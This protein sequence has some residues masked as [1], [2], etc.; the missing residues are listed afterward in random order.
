MAGTVPD[1]SGA[2]RGVPSD[3]PIE[4]RDS[5]PS[6]PRGLEGVMSP[7][8]TVLSQIEGSPPP[9]PLSQPGPAPSRSSRIHSQ[10]FPNGA[11]PSPA[12]PSPA[13]SPPVSP[14]LSLTIEIP[15]FAL[16]WVSR[17]S[18]DLGFPEL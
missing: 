18:S 13:Q 16:P 9:F 5:Y 3:T 1:R 12:Q 11:Q 15:G 4:D 6:K 7:S 2:L 17:A 14:G 10:S 8:S